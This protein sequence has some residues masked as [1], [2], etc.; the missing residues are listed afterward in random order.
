[1][2][3]DSKNQN[4]IS[5]KPEPEKRKPYNPP[6]LIEYGSIKDLTQGAASRN[7]NDRGQRWL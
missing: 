6:E 3:K 7:R 1:M 2:K 4:D 5:K